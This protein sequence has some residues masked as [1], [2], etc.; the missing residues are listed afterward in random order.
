MGDVINEDDAQRLVSGAH[1]DPFSILGQHII[2]GKV[3]IRAYYPDA[4]AIDVLDMKTGKKVVSLAQHADA[5]GVFEG[6]AARRRLRFAYQL[7]I[8]K[9]GH[10][11]TAPDPY[12]FSPV[13]GELDEHLITEGAH[14]DLWKVLGA[15]VMEHE[16][17]QARI[18]RF[19]RQTRAGCLLLVTSTA[20]TAGAIRCAGAVKRACG[21]YSCPAFQTE[22]RINTNCLIQMAICCPKRLTLPALAQSTRPKRHRL[23]ASWMGMRGAT[24]NGC[25]NARRCTGLTS[26]FQSTR[27]TL[28]RGGVF[29]KKAIG[30]C[31]ILSMRRSWSAMS[32]IWV[33]P[34]SS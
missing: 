1:S 7:R 30:R 16:G 17:V 32:R 26:L 9:Q 8:A 18:L 4:D 28:D 31:L 19:G 14:L 5:P 3:T 13:L 15:H 27:F 22:R 10:V 24:K 23:Y 33:S 20:G 34:I 29:P 21:K 12:Q 11:W 6:T 2:D 25:R